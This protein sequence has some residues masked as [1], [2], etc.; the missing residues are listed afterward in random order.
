MVVM[1]DGTQTE[2]GSQI[3]AALGGYAIGILTAVA[4]YLW[5]RV[6]SRMWRNKAA[7]L[8]TARTFDEDDDDDEQPSGDL[9]LRQGNVQILSEK[10]VSSS[11]EP[12]SCSSDHQENSPDDEESH[13][14]SPE[15]QSDDQSLEDDDY[16]EHQIGGDDN[17]DDDDDTNTDASFMHMGG[18]IMT[19]ATLFVVVTVMMVFGYLD[20]TTDYIFYRRMWLTCLC[21]PF[22]AIL[23]NQLKQWFPASKSIQWGTW[24]ANIAGAVMSISLQAAMVRLLAADQ[25][26][27]FVG[28]TLWAL[29]VGFAGSLS[30]VS[31]FVK[32]LISLERLLDRH[33]YA[34]ATLFVSMSLSM[35]IYMPIVR[36]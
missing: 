4:A 9:K 10:E 19:F 8:S 31:T 6:V 29:K 28:A 21:T 24:T 13:L 35:A 12:V 3:A 7:G 1:L 2:N 34:V 16:A 17:D 14:P 23:R 15:F 36:S 20:V 18:S 11:P 30:T 25:E 33:L 27:T 26:E 22:G 32:E 5:G